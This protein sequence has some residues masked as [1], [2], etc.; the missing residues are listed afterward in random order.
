MGRWGGWFAISLGLAVAGGCGHGVV[1]GDLEAS[2]V[3]VASFNLRMNT[4]KDGL[5]A[6][7]LRKDAAVGV[8]REFD[9]VGVQEALPG[10]LAEIDA[11]LSGW[12][13]VG[14]GR[15]DD[16]GGE[17]CSIYY[18]DGRLECLASDTFWLSETPEVPGSMGWD[19]ACPRVATWARL[20]EREGGARFVVVNVH[21]DHKGQEARVMSARLLLDRIGDLAAGDPLLLIGDFNVTETNEVYRVLTEGGLADARLQEGVVVDG[22]AATW[23]G[24]GRDP[25]DRRIDYVFERFD[26]TGAQLLEFATLDGSIGDVLGNDNARY[27]SDHFPVS[28]L[29]RLPQ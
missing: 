9:V 12:Q 3:R 19:A 15:E 8:M 13:R 27:P 18:R 28:A 16:G 2:G 22:P 14:S 11:A 10:M 20:R 21:L 4:V 17:A 25:L 29:V 6:W 24:F 1:F 26:G 23:N 7:P 5:D